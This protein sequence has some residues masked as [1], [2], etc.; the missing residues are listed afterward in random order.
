[1]AAFFSGGNGQHP[2]GAM[3]AYSH[4]LAPS[5]TARIERYSNVPIMGDQ[6]ISDT[7]AIKSAEDYRAGRKAYILNHIENRVKTADSPVFLLFGKREF[8]G[9]S[10]IQQIVHAIPSDARDIPEGGRGG[11]GELARSTCEDFMVR[12]GV[13]ATGNTNPFASNMQKEIAFNEMM[14]LVNAQ[15]DQLA[16]TS[17]RDAFQAIYNRAPNLADMLRNASSSR[18][19]NPD[20]NIDDHELHYTK[21][22]QI[23]F[24]MDK[25]V[26]TMQNFGVMVDTVAPYLGNPKY[27]TMIV[28]SASMNTELLKP[29]RMLYYL[30]GQDKEIVAQFD[31]P[32]Y[33]HLPTGMKI[34]V[35]KPAAIATASSSHTV[36]S[37]NL[38][39]RKRAYS[40]FYYLPSI[41]EIQARLGDPAIDSMTYYITDFEKGDT[42]SFTVDNTTQHG[43]YGKLIIRKCMIHSMGSVIWGASNPA[44]PTG[45]V[46]Y[47]SP[48]TE[49]DRSGTAET[50]DIT[51]RVLL[52]ATVYKPRNLL[53]AYDVKS[54]GIISGGSTTSS[55][56]LNDDNDLYELPPAQLP[57]NL[58]DCINNHE[59]R[60]FNDLEY[61][62]DGSVN[63]NING[64]AC[65]LA[66]NL[67]AA[68]TIAAENRQYDPP[69]PAVCYQGRV[70][71]MYKGV[72]HTIS[73]NTGP[74]GS[75]DDVDHIS[76]LRGYGQLF[77]PQLNPAR[78]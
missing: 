3:Q 65:D 41:Q 2:A 23:A 55:A 46:L 64:Y 44:D 20:P 10:I 56:D 51:V 38:M 45:D 31:T 69:P 5:D 76:A 70:D 28:Q 66:E 37:T 49:E 33:V 29:E 12:R 7:V 15:V 1:M 24:A 72:R 42:K 27:D 35:Y 14:M 73:R 59:I 68:F 17:E 40:Y 77:Q 26:F 62:D 11:I 47:G 36:A 18:H 30:R 16:Q 39:S 8:E 34:A 53:V 13:D 32:A 71:C 6:Y 52:G 78:M 58:R 74:L 61:K 67:A 57:V 54:N 25:Q 19:I 50:F 75:A 43:V 4:G 63:I 60:L 21:V 9:E 48:K 22:T